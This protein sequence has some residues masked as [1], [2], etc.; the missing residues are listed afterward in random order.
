MYYTNVRSLNSTCALYINL[1]HLHRSTKPLLLTPRDFPPQTHCLFSDPFFYFISSLIP[2]SETMSSEQS[3]FEAVFGSSF[4]T[5]AFDLGI[6]SDLFANLFLE[7]N[8]AVAIVCT[9]NLCGAS[10]IDSSAL[11]RTLQGHAL[12]STSAVDLNLIESAKVDNNFSPLSNPYL[13]HSDNKSK[14]LSALDNMRSSDYYTWDA[15]G[16]NS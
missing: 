9:S 15:R 2:L 6:R 14:T 8:S 13:F 16:M 5:A 4:G 1:I 11:F 3:Y 10:V 7:S 12:H